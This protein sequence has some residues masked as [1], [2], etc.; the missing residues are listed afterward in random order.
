MLLSN[1]LPGP[2]LPRA[3]RLT[4]ARPAASPALIARLRAFE[5]ETET[6]LAAELDRDAELRGDTTPPG[7]CALAAALLV[8]AS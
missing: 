3:G 6:Q 1:H 2:R 7:D 5:R 4:A 8:A